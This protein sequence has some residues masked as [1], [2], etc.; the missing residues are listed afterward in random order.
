MPLSLKIFRRAGGRKTL[1]SE[2]ALEDERITVGRGKTCTV[3]LEDPNRYLSR[4][5][6]EFE[7]TARGY[8]LRVMSGISPILVNDVAY[9]QGSEVAVH[10]GDTLTME[11]YDLEIA[12]V[13]AAKPAVSVAAARPPA[14]PAAPPQPRRNAGPVHVN[15]HAPAP[16]PT[17]R[18]GRAKWVAA[19][20]AAIAGVIVLA[21][22]W[23]AIKGLL[24]D[25]PGQKKAEQAIARL[26]GE[27]RAM[28]KLLDGDRQ[29]VKEATTASSREI[30]RAEGLVRSIRASQD[31]QAYDAVVGEARLMAKA[32]IA[33]EER[34]RE[35][36]EGPSGLPKAEGTLS[37]AAAAA[38]GGDRAES[39]RLLEVAVASI[40]QMRAS[41]A[42]DRKATQAELDKRR[43][44]I[45][46]AESRAMTEAEARARADTESRAR[47]KARAEA[48]ATRAFE[49]D[50]V[51]QSADAAGS[52]CLGRLSGTWTHPV[53]GTWTFAGNQGTR[54]AES[55]KFGAKARQ[56]TTMIV[57]G[58]ESDT[59]TYRIVRFALVN[60]DDPGQAYDRTEASAPTL[61]FWRKANTVRYAVSGAGLRIGNYTYEKR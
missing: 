17:P 27:A 21:L 41:I 20:A 43:E 39:V 56:I 13:S 59:M 22:S 37:A 42:E 2:P 29:E 57:S 36:L 34:V 45:L 24:P 61:S 44:G 50:P 32:S 31:R 28:L 52:S 1:V 49:S 58:C 14:A 40:A 46:A 53:G 18:T 5:Q 30:E 25:G 48:D 60:T 9:F 35:R 12:S 19:G 3:V 16:A 11:G 47:A 10:A 33:L 51:T 8:L 54:V 38:R 7:R 6:G 26:E 23:P 55:A 15:V 4:I